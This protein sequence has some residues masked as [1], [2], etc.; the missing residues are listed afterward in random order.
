MTDA[1]K[2]LLQE[3]VANLNASN[4]A[5]LDSYDRATTHSDT[6]WLQSDADNI[7]YAQY[8]KNVRVILQLQRALSTCP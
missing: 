5:L 2:T 4:V 8:R 1:Y 6:G 7:L 3:A